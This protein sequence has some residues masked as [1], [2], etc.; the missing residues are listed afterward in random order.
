MT[1]QLR[2]IGAASCAK[3]LAVLYGIL[4]L[5]IGGLISVVFVLSALIGRTAG[6]PAEMTGGPLNVLVGVGAVLFFPLFYAAIGAVAGLIG[7]TLYNLVSSY[8]GGIEVDIQ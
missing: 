2:S 7:A 1:Q 5:F 8:T 4:G 3:V 6:L